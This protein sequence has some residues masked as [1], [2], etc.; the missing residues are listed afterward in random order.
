MTFTVF[1]YFIS[2]L[3]RVSS[4]IFHQSLKRILGS[5][6]ASRII[7]LIKQYVLIRT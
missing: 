1:L 5:I 2:Y 4:Y 7:T 6:S 3:F